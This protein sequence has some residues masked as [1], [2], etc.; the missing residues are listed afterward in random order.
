M[1]EIQTMT[2]DSLSR[3][4]VLLDANAQRSLGSGHRTC[5]GVV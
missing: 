5:P 2:A 1:T 3:M 4:Q